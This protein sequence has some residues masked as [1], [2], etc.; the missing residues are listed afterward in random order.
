MRGARLKNSAAPARRALRAPLAMSAEPLAG[1]RVAVVVLGDVGRSPR[2]LRHASAL[3]GTG[4]AVELIGYPGADLPSALAGHPGLSIRH[5][6]EPPRAGRHQLSRARFLAY[7]L[8]RASL[9]GA[10]LLSRAVGSAPRPDLW[11]LQTPPALPTLLLPPLAALRGARIVVDWHNLGHTQLALTLGSSHAAVR[12]AR[13]LERRLAPRA[14][15]HLCVSTALQRALATAWRVRAPVVLRDRPA[16][17]LA[18]PTAADRGARRRRLGQLLGLE[19]DG[20]RPPL[21]AISPT[22]WSADEDTDLLLNALAACEA[23]LGGADGLRLV[24]VLTGTG[25]NRARFE[26]RAAAMPLRRAAA[27][28]A[29]LQPDDYATLLGAADVG[30][31]LHRS[32]SGLDLP[33]KIADCFGAGLPV[34]AVDYGETLREMLAPGRTGVLFRTADELARHCL[35]WLAQGGSAHLQHLRA[36]VAGLPRTTWEEGWRTEAL[37]VFARLLGRAAA[38]VSSPAA[39]SA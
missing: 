16:A 11:L 3:L 37:P 13:A 32:S 34:C 6:A 20:P 21:V 19:L 15:A 12:V 33:M 18:P 7:A 28:T 31:C 25:P 17:F 39:R 2:M 35:S 30:I 5:L 8:S 10:R 27:R 22:S 4:A 1:A 29:W 14:H 36:G 23:G 9:L 24:V 38:G 26:A